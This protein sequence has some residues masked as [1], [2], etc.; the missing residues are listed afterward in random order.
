MKIFLSKSLSAIGWILIFV[1]IIPSAS[2]MCLAMG[3]TCTPTAKTVGVMF[4]LALLGGGFLIYLSYKL[5]NQ[6]N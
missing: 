6:H 5:A 3:T 2:V 1:S 4:A